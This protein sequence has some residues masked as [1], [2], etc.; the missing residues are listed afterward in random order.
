[1]G[2]ETLVKP[3]SQLYEQDFVAWLEET[4]R[5]LREGRWDQVDVEHMVEEVEGMANRDRRE[6]MSRLRALILHL[7]KWRCQPEKRSGSWRST[8]IEQRSRLEGLLEQS[9][10]LKRTLPEM[11]GQVYPAA[12]QRASGETG[13]PVKSFPPECPFSVDEILRLGYL[14]D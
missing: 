5:L 3:L 14:P 7:L 1:M 12:V 4:A 2:A 11:A 8:V 9:P 6:L 10:S 13:L